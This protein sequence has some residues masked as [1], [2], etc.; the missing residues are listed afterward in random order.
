MQPELSR[1][2]GRLMHT[3]EIQNLTSSEHGALIQA[4]E[5]AAAFEALPRRWQMVI[6]A[7]ERGAPRADQPGAT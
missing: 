5:T 2:V 3:P 1:R 4:V 6:E 7:A